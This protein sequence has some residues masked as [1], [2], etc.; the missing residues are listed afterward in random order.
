MSNKKFERTK[1]ELF[2]DLIE[3]I[4]F[5]TN[6]CDM[7]DKG[8]IEYSKR[9]AVTLR[10]LLFDSRNSQSILRQSSSSF[11]YTIPDFI[12]IS[13]TQGSL[14]GPGKSNF[15]RASLCCYYFTVSLDA[16]NMLIPKYVNI[17]KGKRYPIR[18]FNAWWDKNYIILIDDKHFLTR[19]D[20]VR[21]IADQDGGAH[22]DPQYDETLGLLKRSI[23]KPFT[24]KVKIGNDYKTY[25]CKIDQVLSATIRS[26]AEETLYMFNNKILPYCAKYLE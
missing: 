23:A 24:L 9:I 19:K 14:P 25:Y 15:V 5:L 7:Y 17:E 10:I 1:H 20:V 18:A 21:L 2:Q 11:V 12:D 8:H 16:D 22:I 6:D 26:I 13:T 3:Q 4:Q